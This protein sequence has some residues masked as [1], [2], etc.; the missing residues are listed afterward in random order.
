MSGI[1]RPKRSAIMPKTMAPIGRIASVI[2]IAKA[3]CGRVFPKACATSPRMSVRMKK[4]NASSVQ[5]RNPASTA[6]RWF[7]RPA[8]VVVTVWMVA[9]KDLSRFRRARL[10]LGELRGR[11]EGGAVRRQ[12]EMRDA[13][14]EEAD[15]PGVVVQR[16][17][18]GNDEPAPGE[19]AADG[20][21]RDRPPV[22]AAVDAGG[23][24]EIL[25]PKLT[26]ADNPIVGDQHP[27]NRSQPARVSEQPR[28]D[29]AGGIGQQLP[30]LN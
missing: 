2:V 1:R 13:G 17:E 12:R 16:L 29:V 14:D 5:P 4:S 28:E 9:M 23:Q 19:C 26:P 6:L 11:V 30:G 3:I 27:C 21:R 7:A 8:S 18:R 20:G 22:P 24:I 25:A 15:K 10:A